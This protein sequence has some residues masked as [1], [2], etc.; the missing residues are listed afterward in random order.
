MHQV[1]LKEV[2][3]WVNDEVQ[4]HSYAQV[5]MSKCRFWQVWLE[6]TAVDNTNGFGKLISLWS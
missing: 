1:C 5:Y 3:F 2:P 6:I 4:M